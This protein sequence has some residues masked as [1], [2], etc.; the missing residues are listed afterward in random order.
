MRR[1]S[2]CLISQTGVERTIL[3]RPVAPGEWGSPEG[4]PS[5][6][7][8]PANPASGQRATLVRPTWLGDLV[9]CANPSGFAEGLDERV[10]FAS[11]ARPDLIGDEGKPSFPRRDSGW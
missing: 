11:F 6:D 3:M 10:W 4:V 5:Q 2:T 9:V 8:I 7:A 1:G